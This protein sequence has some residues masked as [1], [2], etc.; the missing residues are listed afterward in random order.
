MTY[1]DLR[2]ADLYA[3]RTLERIEAV[4]R[5]RA[6]EA[7]AYQRAVTGAASYIDPVDGDSSFRR[8][9]G[10]GPREVPEHT[11]KKAVENSVAGYRMN[12]MA[13]AIIDTYTA[14]CVGDAGLTL[15]VS[16]DQVRPFAEAFWEDPRNRMVSGQELMFRS[17]LLPGEAAQEMMVGEYSGVCRRNPIDTARVVDVVNEGGNPL[18]PQ[19]LRIRSGVVGE[20]LERS[21]VQFDDVAARL[22]GQVLWWPAFQTMETDTRGTPFLMPILDW[23]DSYDRVLSNL[24]DRTALA[25]Y[26]VWD[27]TMKGKDET[28]IAEWV[29][30]RGGLRAPRSGTVE[31]HNE[32]VEWKP[33]TAQ[34]GAYEDTRTGQT[35]MTSMAAGAGLSKVWLAEPE[36]ANRATALS[37]AEPVRRRIGSVQNQWTAN[38]TEMVRFAVDQAVAAGRLPAMVSI[39]GPGESMVEVPASSTVRVTGPQVAAADAKVTAEVLHR[40]SLGIKELRVAGVMT[41]EAAKALAR[42]A[43]EDFAG[44]PYR[45]ELDTD[46]TP[47]DEIATAVEDGGA[48]GLA[49]LAAV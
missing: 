25:R 33:Q 18:W 24:I 17:W 27:V 34:T 32:S 29:K 39:A 5:A 45:P 7:T 30:A 20:L 36:D 47:V 6:S 23:L 31:V 41:D 40:L 16:S 38:V 19:T 21:V 42:K 12:P 3:H 2:T 4:G 14:F 37:M 22:S 11:R 35:V 1:S 9:G 48:P 10:G 43:W 26:L 28:E 46:S 15:Q 13:R 49:A 44:V 8:L